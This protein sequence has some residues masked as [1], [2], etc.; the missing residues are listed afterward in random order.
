MALIE[1][2]ILV[3]RPLA[4]ERV[5]GGRLFDLRRA[6]RPSPRPGRPTLGQRFGLG[7]LA[8]PRLLPCVP[9]ASRRPVAHAGFIWPG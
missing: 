4:D 3:R 9:V 8:H 5:C 7:L 6:A 1:G 2:E